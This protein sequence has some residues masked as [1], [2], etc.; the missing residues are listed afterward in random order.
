MLAAYFDTEKIRRHVWMYIREVASSIEVLKT[1]IYEKGLL[2]L[3][4]HTAHTR[5]YVGSLHAGRL[6][7]PCRRGAG[8]PRG[9]RGRSRRRW[10]RP[11]RGRRV[12]STRSLRGGR[13][14]SC[15]PLSTL[16]FSAYLLST[17]IS[18][19]THLSTVK[20]SSIRSYKD[21]RPKSE[22]DT[23]SISCCDF[24]STSNMVAPTA[25][26]YYSRRAS[27]SLLA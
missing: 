26:L 11:N 8:A 27:R 4:E 22:T 1:G 15:H 24:Y 5:I 3:P 25:T 21:R 2:S 16:S 9:R 7:R 10:C 6:F 14:S 20:L 13:C 12:G 23:D 19:V 18:H 17:S